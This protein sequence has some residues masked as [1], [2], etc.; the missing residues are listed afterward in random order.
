MR[1]SFHL[2]LVLAAL[3]LGVGSASRAQAPDSTDTTA[4]VPATAP[5]GAPDAADEAETPADTADNGDADDAGADA[6]EADTA[7]ARP[8]ARDDEFPAPFWWAIFAVAFCGAVGGFA[9]DLAADGGKLARRKEDSDTI[10]LG[11]LAKPLIGAAAALIVLSLNPP[12]GWASLIGSALAAGIGGEA[13]IQAILAGR[14]VQE[15]EQERDV[16]RQDM[17]RL[18][19]AAG[20]QLDGAA[21]LVRTIASDA[22]R[23][24]GNLALLGVDTRNKLAGAVLT[25]DA[26]PAYD[27]LDR[28]VA[29]AKRTLDLL[30]TRDRRPADPA[31]ET[32][33]G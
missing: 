28:Y 24:A 9:G 32:A 8:P 23:G 13:L 21:D 3:L 30:A 26:A 18:Q 20:A 19:Q 1:V 14:R 11:W 27:A 10:N 12:V 5:D 16:V 7:A 29:D 4:A 17:A 22:Q 2:S 6:A 25:A 31:P 33:E 15:A